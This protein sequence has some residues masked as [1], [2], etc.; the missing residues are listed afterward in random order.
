MKEEKLARNLPFSLFPEVLRERPTLLYHPVKTAHLHTGWCTCGPSS[1]PDGYTAGYVREGYTY[2][3]YMGG[4][5][6]RG[7]I[8]TRVPGRLYRGVIP[9]QGG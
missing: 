6:G 2:L 5:V 9:T 8:P 3:G 1:T 7:Y 4:M